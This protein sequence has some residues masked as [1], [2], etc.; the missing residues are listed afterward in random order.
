MIFL[1]YF[2]TELRYSDFD[3]PV[4][5]FSEN[6]APFFYREMGNHFYQRADIIESGREIKIEF[7]FLFSE[8]S[9]AIITTWILQCP[10]KISTFFLFESIGENGGARMF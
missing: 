7:F 10:V 3:F 2:L 1:F 5:L 6:P 8:S 9:D 4:A